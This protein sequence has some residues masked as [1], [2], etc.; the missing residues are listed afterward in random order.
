MQVPA[1]VQ[2]GQTSRP[3]AAVGEAMLKMTRRQIAQYCSLSVPNPIVRLDARAGVAIYP[4]GVHENCTVRRHKA[5]ATGLAPPAADLD[6]ID[7][8]PVVEV[9]ASSGDLREPR[10]RLRVEQFKPWT[11]RCV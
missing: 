9:D 11:Q 2:V 10:V 1:R 6:V 8:C 3:R 4:V 5:K 7:G